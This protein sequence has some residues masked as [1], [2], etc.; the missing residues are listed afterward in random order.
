MSETVSNEIKKANK[1]SDQ[2]EDLII[3]KGQCPT[4]ERNTLLMAY[5]SLTFEFHRCILCLIDHQFF[6]GAFALVRPIVETVI[7]AHVVIMGSD[8][9]VRKLGRDEYKTNFVTIGKEIDAAFATTDFFENFLANS[10]K[11]L[12]GYTHV[13]T[14]QLSRRFSGMDLISNFSDE[15]IIEAV[16]V[17]TSSIFMVNNLVAKYL[18]FDAEWTKANEL[19]AEWEG[20]S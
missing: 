12:H 13:G 16:R 19:F 10:R 11:A 5:W 2:V 8:E 14:H 3:A 6:S 18:G 15:E 17:S 7:R 9:D 20:N 4:G 1:F